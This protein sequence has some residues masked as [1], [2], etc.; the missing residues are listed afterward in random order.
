MARPADPKRREDILRAATTV[1]LENGYS[2]AR[3]SDIARKAG[4]VVS[5]LYLYFSSKE[6]M[7]RELAKDIRVQVVTATLPILSQL[8]DKD[9]LRLFVHTLFSLA[10]DNSDLLK[11]QLLDTGLQ[12]IRLNSRSPSHG[13]LYYELIETLKQR[14]EQGFIRGYDPYILTEILIG[15]EKWVF[16]IYPLLDE[17]DL[18][19]NEEM[20]VE[21]LSNALLP[22]LN[23]NLT[24]SND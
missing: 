12:S 17:K 20:F 9:D 19:R 1:F 10:A 3:L 8:K 16:E 18:S 15:F 21:W 14:I 24:F 23:D 11:L 22:P 2:E 6:E 7:V 4:I 5:T 13:K